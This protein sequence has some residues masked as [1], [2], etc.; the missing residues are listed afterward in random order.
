DYYQTKNNY[1]SNL[2]T[3]SN[4]SRSNWGTTLDHVYTV[5]ATNVVNVRFNFTRMY[6]DHS[7][8]SAGF[9]PTGFGF[10][11]YLGG[12]SQYSQLPTMTFASSQTNLTALGFGSNANIL[13]S[14]SLQLFGD[15]VTIHGSHNIKIGGDVRQYR[16]NYRAFG[17]S[18]GNFS[19]SAN[20]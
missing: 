20:N 11:S 1:F 7:S 19:F 6:E 2:S 15:W 17:N 12:L 3:G 14:Q 5:N 8:P 13:P 16:L 4:L 9:D 18:T 10:P